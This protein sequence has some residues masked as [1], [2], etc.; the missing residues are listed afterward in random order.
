MSKKKNVLPAFCAE[1][2]PIGDFK[3][4]LARPQGGYLAS[5]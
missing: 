2:W 1:M 5:A 3:V 4:A